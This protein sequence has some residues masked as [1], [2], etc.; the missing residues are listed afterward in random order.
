[1]AT[2]RAAG[3]RPFAGPA[4]DA[5]W[6]PWTVA[7][8]LLAGGF[9]GQLAG[10]LVILPL[11]IGGAGDGDVTGIGVLLGSLA[12]GAAM[13]VTIALLVRRH[14]PLSAASLG[15]R[16]AA[17]GPS[18][19]WAALG[20]ALI[21]AFVFFW[22]QVA[23]LSG[24]FSVPP[25]LDGRSSVAE[26][27]GIGRRAERADLGVGAIAS[28]A[29]RVVVPA[30][31][32]ELVLRGFALQV[33]ANWR[34]EPLAL[35]ITSIL[36]LGPIGFAIGGSGDGAALLPIC[37]LLG[38]VL[39][40]LFRLTGSLLPGIALSA[41]VMAAGLGE[42]FGWSAGGVALLAVCCCAGSVAVAAPLAAR[43][44]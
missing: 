41:A 28:A 23:D 3:Q 13:L 10:V 2:A 6:P 27:L 36:T 4:D 38:V 14:R 8:G 9:A 29:G 16:P 25:E 40:L 33:L 43:A 37:L 20:G 7:V 30:I 32:A 18:L 26:R 24:A 31:I 17:L 5:D 39:G 1:M 15:L 44:R 42:A 12:F 35:A 22:A 34:G 11:A 21:A 19:A